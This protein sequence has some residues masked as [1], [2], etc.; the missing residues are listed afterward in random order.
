MEPVSYRCRQIGLALGL[1]SSKL[2]VIEKEN[3]KVLDRLTEVLKLWLRKEYDVKKFGEPSWS[4]LAEAVRH[5]AGGNDSALAQEI[6][7]KHAGSRSF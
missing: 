5:R 7:K 3:M 6:T 1:E 2:E 4:L